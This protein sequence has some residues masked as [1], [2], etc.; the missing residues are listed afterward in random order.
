MP[1]GQK[2]AP[3]LIV[4]DREPPWYLGIEPLEQLPVLLII[5]PFLQDYY[6]CSNLP[7]VSGLFSHECY[8]GMTKFDLTLQSDT[9]L[10]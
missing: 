2:R 9:Y 4:N 5:E 10:Q 8:F 7:S 1:A 3:D 6:C